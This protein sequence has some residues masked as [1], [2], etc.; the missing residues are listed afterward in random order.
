MV[1]F[2]RQMGTNE[3]HPLRLLVGHNRIIQQAVA[4]HHNAVSRPSGVPLG[5][6]SSVV[7]AVQCAS[8]KR[9]FDHNAAKE[10]DEQI[11]VRIGIHRGHCSA[12]WRC[13]WGWRNIAPGCKPQP[14]R[15]LHLPE[16]L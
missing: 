16:S 11:R 9:I 13:L 3:A 10:L 4:E 14:T 12:G 6:F 1:N 15:H 7:N 5:G 2:S 8:G